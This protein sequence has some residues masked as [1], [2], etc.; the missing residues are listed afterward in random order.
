M[1]PSDPR[2]FGYIYNT[3]DGRHQFWAIKTEGLAQSVVL[4]LRDLFEEVYKQINNSDEDKAQEDQVASTH[5][6][7]NEKVGSL[8]QVKRKKHLKIISKKLCVN[9]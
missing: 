5:T 6:Y 1:D 8:S 4:V 2:A 7:I 9:L 3:T